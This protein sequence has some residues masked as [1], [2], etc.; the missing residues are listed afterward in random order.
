[1]DIDELKELRQDLLVA[2]QDDERFISEPNVLEHVMPYMLDAK[3]IETEEYSRSYIVDS[4][5][6]HKINSF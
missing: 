4:I 5:S 1:M 6:N 3:I 2:A